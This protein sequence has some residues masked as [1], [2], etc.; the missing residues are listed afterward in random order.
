MARPILY[1][2]TY[3]VY[4]RIARLALEEKGVSYDLVEV[5]V[6]APGG[7]PP[8]HLR[9]QAFGR[10]P[11][12]EHDGFRLY[13]TCAIAGYVDEA[14][15]GPPLMPDEARERARVRQVVSIL[16]SYAYRPLVWDVYVERVRA[17]TLCRVSDEARIAAALDRAE[18]CLRA[19]SA[20]RADAEWL[21]GVQFTL[22][23][24]HAAPMVALFCLAPE[25]AALLGRIPGWAAWWE[26]IQA[27]PSIATTRFPIE[28]EL[29]GSATTED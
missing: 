17:H 5:D 4:T 19:L 13:E 11:A 23:D 7:A 16:D 6:F 2:A 28:R 9:R 22:A 1:G 29:E 25:G 21:A 15:P 8:D 3:S 14:F 26:R 24:L 27:R 20:L 12:F 18:T 10:I